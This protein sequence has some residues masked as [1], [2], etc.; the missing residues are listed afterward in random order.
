M[1]QL[2]PTSQPTRN[3]PRDHSIDRFGFGGEPFSREGK[4]APPPGQSMNRLAAGPGANHTLTKEA[5]E[6]I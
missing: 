3:Q 2:E 6:K 5:K 1:N 4:G